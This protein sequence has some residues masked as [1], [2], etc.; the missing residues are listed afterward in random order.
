MTLDE[1]YETFIWCLDETEDEYNFRIADAFNEAKK[2]K[3]LHPFFQ[4]MIPGKSV[5]EPCARVIAS[6]SDEE[7]K[8]KP[9]LNAMFQWLQDINWPGAIIIYDRLL[10]MPFSEIEESFIHI[11]R[12]AEEEK[13]MLWLY[14]LDEFKKE[15]DSK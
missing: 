6:K 15:V 3:Y 1:I 5:W 7:L 9:Y 2:Y 13:D 11:R 12:F 10:Q 8:Q 4:P 14:A